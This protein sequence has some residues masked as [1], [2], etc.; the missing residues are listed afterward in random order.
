M[1]GH[2][3]PT[4]L[5]AYPPQVVNERN[6]SSE[7]ISSKYSDEEGGGKVA[8]NESKMGGISDEE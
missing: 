1:H 5:P 8:E 3:L 7:E 2:D 4:R 6:V